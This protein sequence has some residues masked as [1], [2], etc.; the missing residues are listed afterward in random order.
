[1]ALYRYPVKSMIGE[2]LASA[3]VTHDGLSGDRGYAVLDGTGAIGSA[4]HPR[5]WGRLLSCRSRRP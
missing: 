3:T 4:K 5:K 2:A 1:M